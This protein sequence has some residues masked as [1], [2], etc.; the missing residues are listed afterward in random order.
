MAT[1]LSKTEGFSGLWKE[2]VLRSNFTFYEA[3]LNK[4][5]RADKTLTKKLQKAY[6]V[7]FTTVAE[8]YVANIQGTRGY[9][10]RAE[11]WGSWTKLAPSWLDQKDVWGASNTYYSGLSQIDR[12]IGNKGRGVKQI[13][14]TQ[15]F[16]QF[17]R[18]IGPAKTEA[19][20]DEVV[21]EYTFRTKGKKFVTID[22]QN[23]TDLAQKITQTQKE[24][25]P[26]QLL[27]TAEVKG[28]QSLKGVKQDEWAIVD[29]LIQIMGQS[30][31]EQWRKING[32]SFGRNGR[33][34]RPIIGPSITR[35]MNE[36]S[37]PA[38]KQFNE[39]LK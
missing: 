28:F 11:G 22:I 8:N 31:Y 30:S 5:Q 7:F 33:P 19:I 27:I 12:Y 25:F 1:R 34:I 3:T 6:G 32:T 21:I 36:V 18:S 4:L 14:R 29:K 20:L 38:L 13:K 37:F 15:S 16:D 2:L 9:T 35:F 39:T 10:P 24:G 17:L 26:E 23:T